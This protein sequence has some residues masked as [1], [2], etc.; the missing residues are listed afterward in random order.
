MRFW[1]FFKKFWKNIFGSKNIFPS[2][3]LALDLCTR[4]WQ[5]QVRLTSTSDGK[6]FLDPKIFFHQ[7]WK[8][9][10]GVFLNGKIFLDYKS[11]EEKKIYLISRWIMRFWAFFKKFW[12]NIFGSKNIFPSDVLA[13][14]L[15]TRK[16]QVQVRLTSTS[17]GK[18]FM[19]S[20]NIF[21]SD[22]EKQFLEYL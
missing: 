8:N 17:D 6:I 3:V 1:A 5:V 11:Y 2:D 21:P 9:I 22:V 10:F 15:C 12:K 14:D 20:K 19:E 4:K 13:L 7:T 18:I 16:W